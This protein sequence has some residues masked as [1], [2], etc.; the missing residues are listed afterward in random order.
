MPR[1][2][3]RHRRNQNRDAG[4][5]RRVRL[6]RHCLR[7]T[8]RHSRHPR[9]GRPGDAG[10]RASFAATPQARWRILNWC[11]ST[12][13]EI[14][15]AIE[16]GTIPAIAVES[17]RTGFRELRNREGFLRRLFDL[18][19]AANPE[20]PV[21]KCTSR[22]LSRGATSPRF[23]TPSAT[24]ERGIFASQL[25]RSSPVLHYSRWV[26]EDGDNL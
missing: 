7:A 14:H 20:R 22:G 3:R 6:G 21:P 16:Q 8:A 23:S 25:G 12:R 18:I 19:P 9:T 11:G 10:G 17:G 5:R 2:R 4:N 13:A 15:R 1:R 26:V 24:A